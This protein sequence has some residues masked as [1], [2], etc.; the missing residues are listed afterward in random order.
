MLSNIVSPS[1]ES[2]VLERNLS[3]KKFLKLIR[4]LTGQDLRPF[5]DRWIYG[6]GCPDF[7]VGFWF[8]R[9]KHVIEVGLRQNKS[10]AG[11]ISGSLALRVQELEHSYDYT[12]HFDDELHSFEFPCHSRVRKVR[13]KKKQDDLPSPDDTPEE[14]EANK[15]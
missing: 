6:R 9:K 5:A 3:T 11:R 15:R 1:S 2:E 12:I 4:K 7:T 10:P 8:N 13:K 14:Q